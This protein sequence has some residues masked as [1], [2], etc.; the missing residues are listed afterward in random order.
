M[1]RRAESKKGGKRPKTLTAGTGRQAVEFSYA[2]ESSAEVAPESREQ[3]E[4]VRQATAILGI[5]HVA[6]WMESRIPSLDNQSPYDLIQTKDGRKQVERVL[7]QI[8]HGVY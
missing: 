4:I 6:R 1:I 5:H 8:E 7:L 3:V 2:H